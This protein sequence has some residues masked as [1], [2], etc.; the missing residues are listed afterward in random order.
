MNKKLIEKILEGGIYL[1]VFLLPWQTRLIV[2]PGT[3]N[4]DSW[5]YG[6]ISLYGLDILLF[7]LIIL[8][9]FVG[10]DK[11]RFL[12]PQKKSI[13]PVRSPD[14]NSVNQSLELILSKKR[15]S[16]GINLWYIIVGFLAI[17]FLS[18]YWSW[19]GGL[20]LYGFIKL[21]EGIIL[22]W[23]IIKSS[24]NFT[25]ISIAYVSAAVLQSLIGIYQFVFQNSFGSK[26]LGMSN[27]EI[28]A[29]GTSVIETG[30]G[31]FLRAYGSFP[32]P[33]I[34][35]GFLLV[36]LFLV[37]GLYLQTKNKERR[38]LA[39][40]GLAVIAAGFF[41]SFSRAAWLTLGIS[42]FFLL[43]AMNPKRHFSEWH[44]PILK[45]VGIIATVFLVF[46]ILY[47]Q[48][49]ITRF[50]FN[51]RLEELSLSQRANYYQDAF[52]LIKKHPVSGVG[53]NNYTLAVNYEIDSALAGQEY[54]PVHNVYLLVLAELGVFG[55]LIFLFLIFQILKESW[56]ALTNYSFDDS[57]SWFLICSVILMAIFILF[58]F[59]H[60]FWTLSSGIMLFWFSLGLWQRSIEYRQ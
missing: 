60:Y 14:L 40:A 7:I 24:F 56:L 27:L 3:L 59:D 34:L 33:N 11:K 20:A 26:W 32:H 6:T 52:S 18:I 53:L 10:S 28:A 58:L 22:F 36:G 17:S 2:S 47:P 54:Q 38:S 44:R 21:S 55:V 16:N 13:N 49:I 25:K 41:C 19:N 39:L 1:W 30:T 45:L 37:I 46:F 4:G 50:S 51:E 12:I 48:T 23:F 31:R 5:E 42:L 9:I 29:S 35:A 8:K 57:H 15:T 43:G